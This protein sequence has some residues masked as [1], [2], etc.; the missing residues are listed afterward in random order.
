MKRRNDY[1]K[2]NAM[3]EELDRGSKGAKIGWVMGRNPGALSY[4]LARHKLRKERDKRDNRNNPPRKRNDL[5]DEHGAPLSTYNLFPWVFLVIIVV[6]LIV[7][8]N[9]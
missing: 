2:S 4:E 9:L 5:Y 1:R 6:A 3:D 7:I 8:F